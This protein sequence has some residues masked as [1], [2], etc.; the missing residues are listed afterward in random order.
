MLLIEAEKKTEKQ[1]FLTRF[2]YGQGKPV[3]HL[4]QSEKYI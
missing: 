4:F 1:V 2:L 3:F